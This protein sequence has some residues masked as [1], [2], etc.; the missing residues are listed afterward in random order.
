[1]MMRKGVKEDPG[2]C[3]PLAPCSSCLP[4]TRKLNEYKYVLTHLT[5]LYGPTHTDT[6][7]FLLSEL[8]PRSKIDL[9]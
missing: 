7:E 5:T 9:L 1:M 8:K 3:R 2:P 6:Q 4:P